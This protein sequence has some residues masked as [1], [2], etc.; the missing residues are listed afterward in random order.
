GE[1]GSADTARDP[2]GFAVKFYT[3]DATGIWLATI[4]QYSLSAIRNCSRNTL[5]THRSGIRQTHLKIR[6]CF[7][8]LLVCDRR[9]R[10]K[11]HP[12]AIRHM[13]GYGSH[14]FKLVNSAGRGRV[15]QIPFQKPI[16]ASR[17]CQQIG[18]TNLPPATPTTPSEICTTPSPKIMSNEE[19][20][21]VELIHSIW[22]QN[23]AFSLAADPSLA[24]CPWTRCSKADV[25]SYTDTH[26]HRRLG[27]NYMQLP[28]KLSL[29]WLELATI[30]ATVRSAWAKTKPAP[31]TITRIVFSG[32]EETKQALHSEHRYQLSGEVARQR[33]R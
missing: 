21:Q 33:F 8:I 16:R 17:T 26:R 23:A 5:F 18:L 13:N 4:R 11:A 30:N 14:T 28:V 24:N 6:L 27:T 1:S 31:R 9:L 32:P 7:G 25:Y 12:T 29:Q 3:E 15:L 10:I 2:R 20:E 22:T 19:A